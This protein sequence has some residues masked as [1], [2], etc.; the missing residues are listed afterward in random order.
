MADA[1]TIITD[2]DGPW[3][4][5]LVLS[6]LLTHEF[7]KLYRYADGGPPVDL[8]HKKYGPYAEAV[9]GWV[10][11]LPKKA[12][13]DVWPVAYATS[14]HV[15]RSGIIGNRTLIAQ[16]DVKA[17]SYKQL[18][19][20][21]AR[22][23]REA[24]SL[25]AQAAET[26][27]ADLFITERPYLSETR[28]PYGV[29]VC[30]PEEALAF[31]GLYLRA[32][33]LYITYRGPDGRGTYSMNKGLYYWV[34]TRELLPAAW[35]WFG[36]CVQNA[37]NVGDQSFVQLGGSLLRR[38]QASLQSRD[39]LHIALN[40]EQ[41]NDTAL[42][43]LNCLDVILVSLMGAVDVSARV[44]HKVLGL[45]SRSYQAAWQN[46]NWLKEIRDKDAAL[47]SIVGP[48]SQ[49]KHTVTV[50]RL[51]R[52]SVHGEAL[53]TL[54]VRNMGGPIETRVRLPHADAAD[55]LTAM[56]ALGGRSKWGVKKIVRGSWD[57]D[58]GV[59]V[60]ELFP[61]VMNLLNNLMKLTPVENLSCVNIAA[62]DEL[63]PLDPQGP[64]NPR[65]REVIRWQLGF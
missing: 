62:K 39:E 9:P 14:E 12:G 33:G 30:T 53:S 3:C 51:L 28:T 40:L 8:P 10:E 65:E 55:I 58:P 25:A 13:S 27:H 57:A 5:K 32:Q 41:N 15:G 35:R 59:L 37:S 24:D 26:V 36:A 34:G 11:V 52:N 48:N 29:M 63:P 6:G 61:C 54:A 49:G 56:D 42:E 2:V 7:V 16:N 64:F 1:D 21:E 20:V 47:A 22:S 4:P 38:V 23:R 44:A 43:V 18:G 45:Q 50:L 31:V 17:Q 19:E 46:K 60:E